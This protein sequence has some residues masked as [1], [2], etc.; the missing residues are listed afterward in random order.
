MKSGSMGLLERII[1]GFSFLVQDRGFRMDI[2][3]ITHIY[4]QVFFRKDPIEIFFS[5]ELM[6]DDFYFSITVMKCGQ[7]Y[8]ISLMHEMEKE[9]DERKGISGTIYRSVFDYVKNTD[10]TEFRAKLRTLYRKTGLFVLF[11]KRR[12]QKEIVELHKSLLE[13][14]LDDIVQWLEQ[15]EVHSLE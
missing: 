2:V 10:E 3:K 11:G 5:V 15:D 14:A 7:R 8:V 13:T 4:Y 6:N 1:N 12:A 9:L